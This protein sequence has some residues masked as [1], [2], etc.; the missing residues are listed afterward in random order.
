MR[1]YLNVF[2]GALLFCFCSISYAINVNVQSTSKDVS[3]LGFTVNGKNHGGRGN[4]YSAKNMPTGLY[5][6]GIRVGGAIFG[7]D[8]SC[9]T[10]KGTNRVT[11]NSDTNAILEYNGKNCKLK[12]S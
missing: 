11:L 7:K 6:F 1:S 9:F 5:T 12:I 2:V 10:D 3:A 8:I 4:S